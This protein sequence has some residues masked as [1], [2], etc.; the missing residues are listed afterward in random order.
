MTQS[1]MGKGEILLLDVQEVTCHTDEE[2]TVSVAAMVTAAIFVLIAFM[3]LIQTIYDVYLGRKR[4]GYSKKQKLFTSFSLC[5][6]ITRLFGE[7]QELSCLDGLRVLSMIWI[8]I[9][10]RYFNTIWSKNLENKKDVT[11][12]ENSLHS[13]IVHAGTIAVETFFVISG[14]LVSYGFLKATKDKSGS[15]NFPKFYLH[16]Y[17]R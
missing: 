10:H 5:T 16:R 15:I 14:L 17:L 13:M 12:W 3:V 2:K 9:F 4:A 7:Q 11:D 6:N 8:L 1:Y